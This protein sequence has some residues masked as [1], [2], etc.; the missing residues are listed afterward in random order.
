MPKLDSPKSRLETLP[1][2]LKI[3]ILEFLP[4]LYDLD[5]LSLTCTT[6]YNISKTHVWTSAQRRLFAGG[7]LS[8]LLKALATLKRYARDGE[9]KSKLSDVF[10]QPYIRNPT[11]NTEYLNR[12]VQYRNVIRWFSRRFF[13]DMFKIF[14]SSRT[15]KDSSGGDINQTSFRPSRAET[16]RVDQAF[17]V[18]W[19]YAEI[20]YIFVERRPTDM[21]E[22]ERFVPGDKRGLQTP[23]DL[24]VMCNVQ[25]Y[26]MKILAPLVLR[27]VE[28]KPGD[29]ILAMS[30]K[31]ECLD[32]YHRRGI[33]NVLQWKLGLDGLKELLESP[34][35]VQDAI[36]AKHYNHAANYN[37]AKEFEGQYIGHFARVVDGMWEMETNKTG[38]KYHHRPLWRQKGGRY[39]KYAAPW[40]QSMEFEL[41]AAF[42]DDERLKNMGFYLPW[43]V[44]GDDSPQHGD[45]GLEEQLKQDGC[46]CLD[47]WACYNQW[48]LKKKNRPVLD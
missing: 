14:G 6:F 11:N 34:P 2:E 4:S 29:E 22:I 31:A 5:A 32:L 12:L 13:A 16:I 15:G 36:I 33:P 8:E 7:E 35:D 43:S 9:N 44:D 46:Q 42:Y 45:L 24:G 37:P 30:K 47:D 27:H 40:N 1:L 23:L 20:T 21:E 17:L 48:V 19:I 28:T 25:I 26:L 38:I 39:R 41:A 10:P 18:Q 3:G